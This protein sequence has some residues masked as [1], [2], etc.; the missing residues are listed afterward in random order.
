MRR[1]GFTLIELLVV[2][3]VLSILTALAL[4]AV[5]RAREAARRSRCVNNLKQI[6][7]AIHNYESVNGCYPIVCTN[8]IIGGKSTGGFYSIHTRLLP[9]LEQV[10]LYQSINFSTGTFP[11]DTYLYGPLGARERAI[12]KA[13]QTVYQTQ[14]AAFLCPSDG[15]PFE[16]TGNSYRGNVGTGLSMVTTAEHPDSGNGFFL[17]LNVSYPARIVDGLSH[18]AAFSERLRGSNRPTTP[19]PSRDSFFLP[20][21]TLTADDLLK[22]CRIAA[23]PSD[24]PAYATGGQF[25]FWTGKERTLYTHTETP[26]GAVPD[27][28]WGGAMTTAGMITARSLH[29]G[30]VNVLMGDG[31]VRFV[32]DGIAQ[33][34]WR[35]FGTRN[36][37]ELV[38]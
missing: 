19:V 37:G 2:L 26:N 38:D 14:V 27:C 9:Y 3:G 12:N 5:Q 8:D 36:G 1:N 15:G 11:T 4:P 7:L 20:V 24:N 13:N 33:A 35:G 18:T 34:V 21:I 10:S 16:A 23:R 31:T 25:W 28:T 22:G 32:P 29:P 17:E 6:G 30:G